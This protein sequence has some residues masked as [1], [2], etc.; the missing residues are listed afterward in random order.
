[1]SQLDDVQNRPASFP[2]E[3]KTLQRNKFVLWL[4]ILAVVMLGLAAFTFVSANSAGKDQKSQAKQSSADE[5]AM[6]IYHQSERSRIPGKPVSAAEEAMAIYHASE[7]STIQ[8][9]YLG[10]NAVGLAIYQASERNRSMNPVRTFNGQ[11]FNAYQRSE[12]LGASR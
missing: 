4:G 12:W 11:P 9:N 10:L 5:A 3:G 7:R 1:M 6:A 8:S 2:T